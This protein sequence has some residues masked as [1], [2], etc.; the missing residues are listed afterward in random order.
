MRRRANMALHLTLLSVSCWTPQ[1]VTTAGHELC[2]PAE[3][4]DA[5]ART[6]GHLLDPIEFSIPI[7]LRIIS[8][9]I[10][11]PDT[12]TPTRGPSVDHT[13]LGDTDTYI[14]RGFREAA[15]SPWANP[16]HVKT[17]G[18]DRAVEEYRKL[19]STQVHMLH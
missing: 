8:P 5:Y 14:G 17:V 3:L 15:A 11:A 12:T 2:I 16:F 10:P 7:P 6:F 1:V 4:A 13:P 19:V 18:R 9:D